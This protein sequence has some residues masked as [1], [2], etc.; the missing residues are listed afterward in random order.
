MV[1]FIVRL[2]ITLALVKKNGFVNR[3]I[4][5]IQRQMYGADHFILQK[6]VGMGTPF[7]EKCL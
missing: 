6:K 4:E 3:L 2:I 1:Y 7:F 5:Y